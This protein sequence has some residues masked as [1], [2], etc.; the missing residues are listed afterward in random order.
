MY[1][2]N[3]LYLEYRLRKLSIDNTHKYDN[4]IVYMARIVYTRRLC[5]ISNIWYYYPNNTI[6]M[7]NY[8]YY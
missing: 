3:K 6:L 5:V 2:L 8:C 1:K 7:I 4:T